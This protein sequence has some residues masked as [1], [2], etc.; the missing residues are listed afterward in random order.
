MS[1]QLEI[2]E[3]YEKLKQQRKDANKRYV[4]KNQSSEDWKQKRKEYYQLNKDKLREKSRNNYN[5]Y[6]G[7][8][9]NKEKKKA[10]YENNKEM[11]KIKN[12]YNYY[13]NRNTVNIFIE[14]YPDR[15]KK[16]QEI[17]YI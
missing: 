15:F 9:S 4:L 5:K 12:S 2:I 7:N 6:Y 16:L 14:K 10:Y 13:K 3:K 11:I 17:N 8:T 1:I